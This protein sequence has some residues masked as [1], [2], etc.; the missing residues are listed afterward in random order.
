MGSV[1]DEALDIFAQQIGFQIHR[2]AHLAFAQHGNLKGMRDDP[3]AETFLLDGGH[4][5]A[6]AV[7]GHRSFEYEVAH[8]LRRRGN[9]E[10]VI[11]AYA[12]PAGDATDSINMAGYKMAAQFAVGA[13]G[14]FEIDEGTGL[15]E[16]EIGAIPAFLEQV[17]LDEAG[18]SAH[19]NLN[20]RQ[21]AAI[22]G[23]A[24]AHFKA[25]AAN[26]GAHSQID[27]PFRGEDFFNNAG[28]LYNT[29]EHGSHLAGLRARLASFSRG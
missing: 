23:H 15:G 8:D 14:T 28:F 13:K 9:I 26:L 16:L 20:R 5:Q 3:D 27:G 2:V 22:N 21:A 24:I 25:V 6:D 29:C 11:L 7:H 18:L 10:N 17:E 19:G 4:G 12:F 1:G